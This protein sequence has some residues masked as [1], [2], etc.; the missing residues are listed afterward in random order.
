MRL[1]GKRGVIESPFTDEQAREIVGRVQSEFASSLCG[2]R[3]LSTEQRWWLHK[4]AMDETARAEEVPGFGM[5]EELF[6]RAKKNGIKRPSMRFKTFDISMSSSGEILVWQDRRP[7]AKVFGEHL[8]MREKNDALRDKL[9][10]LAANPVEYAAMFGLGTGSCCFCRKELSTPE[11]LSVGYGPVCAD[12]WGLP[13]GQA[14]VA[15]EVRLEQL[16]MQIAKTR[17]DVEVE[18]GA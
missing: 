17:G 14:Y 2:R 15:P 5:L 13:G 12:H 7:R 4:L 3:H 8:I 11:S 9:V 16:R 18:G 6:L 1:E 10:R